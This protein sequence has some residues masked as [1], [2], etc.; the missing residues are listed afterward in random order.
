MYIVLCLLLIMVVLLQAGK[1]GGM[2]VAFGGAA[3]QSMFSSTGAG[4]FMTRL[5]TIL[6]TLFMV[7]S[8]V[9]SWASSRTGSERLKRASKE[10]PSV[11]QI[12]DEELGG[13]TDGTAVPA[14]P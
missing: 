14:V 9:L 11:H 1:G 3:S 4:N 2:G 13:T 6:A 12:I 10:A 8:L 7:F 5:T